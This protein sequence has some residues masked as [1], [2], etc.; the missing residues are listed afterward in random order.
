MFMD[1]QWITAHSQELLR[2]HSTIQESL[3]TASSSGKVIS[4]TVS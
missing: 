3:N 2:G 1:S 4:V